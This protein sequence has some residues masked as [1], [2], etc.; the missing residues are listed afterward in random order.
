MNLVTR[1]GAYRQELLDDERSFY[2]SD[3]TGRNE[4]NMN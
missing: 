2:G 1:A 4:E 3:R